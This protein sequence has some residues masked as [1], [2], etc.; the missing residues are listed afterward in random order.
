MA[1]FRGHSVM[2]GSPQFGGALNTALTSGI[3]ML[4]VAS[5][6]KSWCREA[7]ELFVQQ[8]STAIA[9]SCSIWC[10]FLGMLP[11]PS[12]LHVDLLVAPLEHDLLGTRCAAF[13]HHS[14]LAW[15]GVAIPS[16]QK[17]SNRLGFIGASL[18]GE[19]WS[20]PMAV[21]QRPKVLGPSLP[22]DVPAWNPSFLMCEMSNTF[23]RAT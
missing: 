1:A 23:F 8:S 22:H 2:I 10:F 17:G 4:A 7:A 19:A 12:I 16:F 13:G 21:E 9:S 14:L 5:Q 6:T 15:R 3:L 18:F 20:G 11:S